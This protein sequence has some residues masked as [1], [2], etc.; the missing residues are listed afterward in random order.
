MRQ[1]SEIIR[2]SPRPADHFY[3]YLI[4]NDLR[5]DDFDT[6]PETTRFDVLLGLGLLSPAD[7][8]SGLIACSRKAEAEA[9]NFVVKRIKSGKIIGRIVN[10]RA[11]E[12]AEHVWIADVEVGEDATR[13]IMWGGVQ[14]LRPDH[15]VAVALPGARL[16][17]GKKLRARTY[18]YGEGGQQ[19]RVR[20]EGMLLSPEEAGWPARIYTANQVVVLPDSTELAPGTNIDGL[21]PGPNGDI[22]ALA[23]TFMLTEPGVPTRIEQSPL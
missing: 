16:A 9:N 3:R 19:V 14:I 8:A 22:S 4:D 15:C 12:Q 21:L 6:L 5:T 18:T 23:A 1:V 7:V 17:N 11:I 20:S 13:Q 10:I 2:E